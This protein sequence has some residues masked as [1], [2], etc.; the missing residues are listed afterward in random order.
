MEET[1]G[2]LLAGSNL[3]KSPVDGLRHVDLKGLLVGLEFELIDHGFDFTEMVPPCLGVKF[4]EV[5][6]AKESWGTWVNEDPKNQ[7]HPAQEL[8]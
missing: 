8:S 4:Q 3:G 1:T 2:D 5:F 6:H 7:Q